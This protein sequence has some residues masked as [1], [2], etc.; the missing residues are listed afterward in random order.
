MSRIGYLFG[1]A[2]HIVTDS[3][4]TALVVPASLALAMTFLSPFKHCPEWMQWTIIGMAIAPL[5]A[6]ALLRIRDFNIEMRAAS[7]DQ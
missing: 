2:L 1:C 4:H 3:R 6:L 5:L 7:S